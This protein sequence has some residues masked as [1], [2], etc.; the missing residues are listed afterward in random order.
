MPSH[1]NCGPVVP[2]PF[3]GDQGGTRAGEGV[4]DSATFLADADQLPHQVS[5]LA[6]QVVL[7]SLAHAL[8]QHARQHG[9]AA[10]DGHVALAPPHHVFRLV[11]ET[12]QLRPD[13]LGLV[14]DGDAAPREARALQGIG[15]ERQLPPVGEQQHRCAILQHAVAQLRGATIQPERGDSRMPSQEA[16]RAALA[17]A[18][19]RG[20]LPTN[21]KG[22]FPDYLAPVMILAYSVRLRGIEVCTL[23]DAHRQTEGVQSNRRKG[24]RDNVTE[25]DAAMIGAWEQLLARRHRIWNRKGRVR[26]VPLR[27]SDRFLLVERGGDPITKSALDSAWQRFITEAVRA[28]VISAAERFALHGLK[29][30]GITDGDNKAA[31]GHVTEAMRQ[32][33]DHEMPVVQPPGARNALERGTT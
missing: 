12:P 14:P 27:A 25:W 7:V 28:G 26:P 8:A 30:R 15:C 16:F 3:G 31:G 2:L 4:E 18:R 13:A 17:F 11:T 5:G 22:S 9:R 29:H 23:T 10:L 32:R 20:A 21:A 1:L 33:Y 24:S 19:E 6:G